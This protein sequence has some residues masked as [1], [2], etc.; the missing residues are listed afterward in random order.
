MQH[1][2]VLDADRQALDPCHPA[3]AREL[4]ST[5]RAAVFRRYPFAIILKARTATESVLHNHRLKIDPGSRTT[6]FAIVQEHT[7]RIVWAAELNHR[8]QLIREA[9]LRRNTIRRSRRRR[10]TRY[11]KPRF[12]NRDRPS[13]WLP[14]S[15]QHRVLTT[16]TWVARLRQFCPITAISQELVRFDTQLMQNPE[17]NGVAYQQGEL[18][19][20]EIRE[21]LLEKFGRRCAY[22]GATNIPLEIEHIVPRSR[23]GSDRVSNLTLACHDCNQSKSNKTAAEFG[24]PNVQAQAKAPLKDAAVTNSTR[25]ALYRQLIVTGLPVEVG[26]GGRTKYNRVRASLP[27]AHWT[28][29]ACVG[30][31][32]PQH[33]DVRGIYPL[34]ISAT[35]HGHRQICGTDRYGFPIRH[36]PRAKRFQGWQTGDLVCATLQRGKFAGRHIGRLRIRHRP[37]FRLNRFDVHPKYLERLQRADG[38]MYT[39]VAPVSST[40]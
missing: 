16:L 20:Y 3:R 23:G 8:G 9:L 22:C 36:R 34:Y 17:I 35:G 13:G 6:G 40:D 21:Y 33:L 24:H 26:T 27:K 32:T 14:P 5:G 2:F 7:K 4:L 1:V 30:V 18:I 10:K 19:G 15:V 37:W 31:S 11:R 38:Y 25:W 29:A 28:D 12:L 39:E